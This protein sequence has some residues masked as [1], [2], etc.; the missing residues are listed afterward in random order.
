M[1][2]LQLQ[3]RRFDEEAWQLLTLKD[4]DYAPF[5]CYFER[6]AQFAPDDAGV[7][8]SLGILLHRAGKPEEALK[9]FQKAVDLAVWSW[10]N[11]TRATPD[12]AV[13]GNSAAATTIQRRLCRGLGTCPFLHCH[14]ASCVTTA[15]GAQ[16]PPEG[17]GGENACRD[18]LPQPGGQNAWFRALFLVWIVHRSTMMGV[19]STNSPEPSAGFESIVDV[20]RST[21]ST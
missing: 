10:L 3:L 8:N 11:K 20:P 14:G 13:V 21:L 16:P 1:G 17:A 15:H 7:P 19:Y 9:A 2:M 4:P 12:S 5:I 6:A 18:N